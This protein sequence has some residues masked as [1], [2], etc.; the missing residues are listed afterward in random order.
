MPIRITVAIVLVS[1]TWGLLEGCAKDREVRAPMTP[2]PVKSSPSRQPEPRTIPILCMHDLGPNA[3]NEYSIK[4]ADLAKYL[5]WLHDEGFQTVTVRD[6][7]AYLRGE[8]QLPPKPIVLTF[9]DNWKS[10]LL[11]AKPMLES[12][13]YVGVAFVI[14]SSVGA[15]EKRLTWEDCQTLA[16]AGW[17]IGSH[18]KTHENLTHVKA[19]QRPDSIRKMVEVEI[20]DSKQI[21]EANTGLE[22]TSFALPFGNYDT[23]VLETLHNAGY[24]AAVSLDRGPADSYSDPLCLPRRMIMNATRF[25]TFKGLCQGE[26]LHIADLKPRPGSRLTSAT[27]TI[28]GTLED[29]DV[30]SP[31]TAEV[32]ASKISVAQVVLEPGSR[33]MTIQAKLFRGA[34]SI[35]VRAG[36]RERSWLLIY[37]M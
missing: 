27:I 12:Y 11:I 9:D 26:S 8:T 36:N 5:K 35:V 7:A 33:K 18:S 23:F 13:G 4:T 25:E 3:Q 17:E 22:V 24:T 37:D 1:L 2:V 32:H 15:N 31:P 34:N 30:S 19:G 20:C 10:A 29:E 16:R 21:I 28:T 14:A 6:V